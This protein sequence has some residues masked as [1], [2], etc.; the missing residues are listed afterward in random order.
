MRLGNIDRSIQSRPDSIAIMDN[1]INHTDDPDG[2]ISVLELPQLY[3]RP[4]AASLLSTLADL[5]TEP[6]SWDPV[7]SSTHTSRKT[8]SSEGVPAYLTKIIS[9]PLSW[10]SDDSE[11]ERIWETAAQRLSER[12]GRTGMGAITRSFAI[13]WNSKHADAS[14]EVLELTL[15]EPALTADNLGLKTW[16]S[17]YLLAKRLSILRSI[18]P[19]LSRGARILELGAGTGLVG[20]AAAAIFQTHVILTDLPEIV[21]NLDQNVRANSTILAQH[22]GSCKAGVLDWSDPDTL[23]QNSE[24]SSIVPLTHAHS[25][26]LILAADP[27]YSPEHPRLLVN[28]IG[29]HLSRNVDTARV[30]IELPLR[31]AYALERQDLIERMTALGLVVVDEGEE[32]G[33]DDWASGNSNELS[34]V[35]CWFAI[36]GWNTKI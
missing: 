14:G 22:G 6:L 11:R 12:S 18:L 5:G 9:N 23:L 30:V 15:H 32:V 19:P 33:Y 21:Q 16:A 28:A 4:S 20:L 29:H 34:E 31:E 17:S 3:Q 35:K 13:P 36:W 8:I 1:Q 10:I 7:K 25:F 26:P 2:E 24:S 27:I